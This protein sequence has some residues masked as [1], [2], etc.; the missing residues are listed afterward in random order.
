MAIFDETFAQ[1]TYLLRSHI[2]ES[3]CY[4]SILQFVYHHSSN[5]KSSKQDTRKDCSCRVY[6][7]C[8]QT[9]PKG[10]LAFQVS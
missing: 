8:F 2:C 6:S 1:K 5:S 3:S 9:K 7:K 10:L 4:I